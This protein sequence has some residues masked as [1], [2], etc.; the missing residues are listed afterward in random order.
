MDWPFKGEVISLK[1][2]ESLLL[3]ACFA[4]PH[5]VSAQ[6]KVKSANSPEFAI[7]RQLALPMRFEVNR[8]QARSAVDFVASAANYGISLRAGRATLRLSHGADSNDLR[9]QDAAEFSIDLLGANLS[10]ASEPDEQLAGYSNYLFGSDPSKWITQVAQYA[11]VRYT[12]IY[13]GVDVIYYG[14]QDRLEHDFVVHPG[15]NPGQ[16]HLALLGAQR[17]KLNEEGDLVLQLPGGEAK[18]RRPRVYQQMGT[19]RIEVA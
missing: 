5:V 18:L 10:P 17:K 9:G 7:T 11:K 13:P 2:L 6:S 3:L 4:S 12:N 15:A 8:G 1:V 16:I 19:R 14:N